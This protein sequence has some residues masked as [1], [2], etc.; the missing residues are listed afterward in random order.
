MTYYEILEISENASETVIHMAY[1]ALAKKYHPDMYSG[2]TEFAEEKMKELNIA[3]E[4]LSDA[5]KRAQYDSLLKAENEPREKANAGNSEVYTQTEPQKYS[6]RDYYTDE[7]EFDSK[8]KSADER[9][10]PSKSRN[11]LISMGIGLLLSCFLGFVV[12]YA[13]AD[14]FSCNYMF[15]LY[16][17]YAGIISGRLK[18]WIDKRGI[19]YLILSMLIIVFG[20][21]YPYYYAISAGELTAAGI[22]SDNIDFLGFLQV[23]VDIFT[24]SWI[25]IASLGVSLVIPIV[26]YESGRS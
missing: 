4:V 10:K 15:L 18:K 23:T 21:V 8:E 9:E 24:E 13:I 3:Y 12:Y 7:N 5:D 20:I 22:S 6:E 2:D 25:R 19:I 14:D 11:P 17:A 26:T 1:K 16:I